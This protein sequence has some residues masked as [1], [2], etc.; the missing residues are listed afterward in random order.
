MNVDGTDTVQLT[1][2]R[3]WDG[4][5]SWSP[6]GGRIIFDTERDGNREIYVMNADGSNP[7]NLTKHPANDANPYWHR[8]E[9]TAVSPQDKL[10]T[11]WGQVKRG[12]Q[13]EQ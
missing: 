1:N 7:V 11:T 6:D 13:P 10:F 2:H 4:N 12:N 8:T 3:G 9:T 5:P